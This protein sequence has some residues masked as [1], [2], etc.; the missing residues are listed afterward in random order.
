MRGRIML[1]LIG[2]CSTLIGVASLIPGVP[3]P[4]DCKT[5]ICEIA[6]APIS[7]DMVL[8]GGGVLLILISRLIGKAAR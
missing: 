6:T 2:L 3:L 5:V 1:F 8:I 4:I 7:L